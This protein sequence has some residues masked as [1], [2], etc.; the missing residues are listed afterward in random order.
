MSPRYSQITP[1]EIIYDFWLVFDESGGLRLSRGKPALGR[2]ERGMA[3]SA[4]LPRSLFATPT[5]R[6]KI[7]VEDN[8]E[9]AVNLDLA[10]ETLR[11]ALGVDIDI[12]LVNKG[13][14]A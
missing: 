13:E 8:G 7:S 6:A 11:E 5:L 10:A 2:N 9:T 3:L 1:K 12:Q 14:T 4:T